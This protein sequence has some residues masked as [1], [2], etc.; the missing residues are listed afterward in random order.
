[1][2]YYIKLLKILEL[3]ILMVYLFFV[4][5]RINFLE[6]F[7]VLDNYILYGRE[8]MISNPSYLIIIYDIIETVS[9]IFCIF[10][11]LRFL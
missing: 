8:Q 2:S 10:I 7:P 6:I 3:I 11:F 4:E 5:F 1:M 9:R